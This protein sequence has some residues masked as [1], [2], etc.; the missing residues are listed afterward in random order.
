MCAFLAIC[1]TFL[2]FCTASSRW[3]GQQ[4]RKQREYYWPGKYWNKSKR[5]QQVASGGK[6]HGRTTTTMIIFPCE[7][8]TCFAWAH[9]IPGGMFPLCCA[10]VVGRRWVWEGEHFE[11][12]Q[13]QKVPTR[14]HVLQDEGSLVPVCARHACPQG[15]QR[16]S[17]THVSWTS[18]NTTYFTTAQESHPVPSYAGCC[19]GSWY[20]LPGQFCPSGILL[21][22]PLMCFLKPALLERCLPHTPV[23]S[24]P[25]RWEFILSTWSDAH[26]YLLV[27]THDQ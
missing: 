13:Q 18:T 16:L 22:W 2:F 23:A 6:D 12:K 5:R 20:C 25:S 24:T 4:E 11:I 9:Y 14:R 7:Y 10:A 1:F 27:L 15:H 17:E 19:R 3:W 8:S 21:W 26:W